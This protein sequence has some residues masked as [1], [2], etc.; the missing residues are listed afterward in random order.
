[1]PVCV[2]RLPPVSLNRYES[3]R[4]LEMRKSG[5][6]VADAVAADRGVCARLHLLWGSTVTLVSLRTLRL[7]K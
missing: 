3:E 6:E 4:N 5:R 7:Y 2:S 1:V